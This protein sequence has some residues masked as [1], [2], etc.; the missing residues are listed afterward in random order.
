V[1]FHESGFNETVRELIYVRVDVRAEA[2][3]RVRDVS[4]DLYVRIANISEFRFVDLFCP[5]SWYA[6]VY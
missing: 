5:V 3:I 1:W 4:T 2:N 6:S